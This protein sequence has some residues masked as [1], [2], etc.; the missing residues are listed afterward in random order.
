MPSLGTQ[1]DAICA[2]LGQKVHLILLWN[3]LY[4]RPNNPL[5]FSFTSMKSIQ[6]L[7]ESI[8][9]TQHQS[10]SLTML[11]SGLIT[12]PLPQTPGWFFFFSRAVEKVD[13]SAH[14]LPPFLLI[15]VFVRSAAL[16]YS[17]VSA[18]PVLG[19]SLLCCLNLFPPCWVEESAPSDSPRVL[20]RNH[21]SWIR[22]SCMLLAYFESQSLIPK[23]FLLKLLSPHQFSSIITKKK[24]LFRIWW[25]DS[26][27]EGSDIINITLAAPSNNFQQNVTNMSVDIL[28]TA[29]FQISINIPWYVSGL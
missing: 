29:W 19:R 11:F 2:I 28:W 16:L 4:H 15:L 26:A 9:Y 3:D 1:T 7:E 6:V 20:C 22:S 17:C 27:V 12:I 24:D 18:P 5:L 10:R 21:I 8:L 25:C 23:C 13:C 14:N